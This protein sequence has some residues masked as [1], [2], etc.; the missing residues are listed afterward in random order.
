MEQAAQQSP[1]FQVI[2]INS[3]S[4]WF[5]QLISD[6]G[7][8][9]IGIEADKLTLEQYDLLK[10]SLHTASINAEL[11][12]TTAL[13]DQI[14]AVKDSDELKVME[15]AIRIADK[16]M[17]SVT[18]R[19]HPGMTELDVA[20][21]MELTMRELG[22][23]AISFDTIVAAGPNGAKPHHRPTSRTIEK[24]EPIVIDMGAKYNWYCSDITRT[25]ILGKA[26]ATF[27]KVYDTV[28][29]AQETAEATVRAAMTGGETDELARIVI[30]KAGHGEHFGHSL[31]HGIGLA[32][33]EYPRVGPSASNPLT[34]GMVFTIEPGIYLTGWGGVRIEDIVVLENGLPRIITAAH[35]RD[36]INI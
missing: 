23:D 22:A 3:G 12:S 16:A 18:E 20:W 13:I 6:S 24:G 36:V 15:E 4:G 26:D 1:L 35:K 33:H 32:V 34:D 8:R 27:R 31:G 28:L 9:R 25:V 30:D 5:T 14:R 10:Q 19:M 7:V 17:D 21:Q 11:V 2:R 29:A